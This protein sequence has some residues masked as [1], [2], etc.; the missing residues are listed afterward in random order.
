LTDA[1]PYSSDSDDKDNAVGIV[2]ADRSE[3]EGEAAQANEHKDKADKTDKADAN[4]NAQPKDS[5]AQSPEIPQP[6]EAQDQQQL[7]KSTRDDLD[8]EIREVREEFRRQFTKCDELIKR[9]G[10]AIKK[11]AIVKQRDIC[12]EIK[13]ILAEEIADQKLSVRT[14]DRCCP[15]QWKRITKPKKDKLSFPKP[16]QQLVVTQGGK[17]ETLQEE[18]APQVIKS[19]REEQSIDKNPVVTQIADSKPEQDIGKPATSITSLSTPIEPA[20]AKAQ[21]QGSQVDPDQVLQEPSHKIRILLSWDSLSEQM[22]RAHSPGIEW[23][24]LSGVLDEKSRIVSNLKLERGA[25]YDI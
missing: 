18:I 7:Q 10:N 22:A 16:R 6:Q 12:H 8:V 24:W 11:A 17:S 4:S 2:T 25:Q 13:N 5:Q 9:L 20:A 3:I 14:I 15:D 1:G 23:V 21:P 19:Y